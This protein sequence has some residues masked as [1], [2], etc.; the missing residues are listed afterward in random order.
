MRLDALRDEE[1]RKKEQGLPTFQTLETTPL[2][3]RGEEDKYLDDG[4][5]QMPGGLRRD[6]SVVN[7]VGM[8][9]GRRNPDT[10]AYNV[11][12]A[13]GSPWDPSGGMG[14]GSGTGYAGN[15]GLMPPQPARRLSGSDM[16]SNAGQAGLGAGGGGVENPNNGYGYYQQHQQQGGC[17]Y[18]LDCL[19]RVVLSP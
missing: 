7:G 14:S 16:L 17:E 18:F 13:G 1:L 10:V 9:Y 12:Y 15:G 5:Q 2:T 11:G 8:G 4:H 3:A 6:G 19:G